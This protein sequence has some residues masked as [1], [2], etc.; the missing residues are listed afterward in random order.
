MKIFAPIQLQFI[1]FLLASLALTKQVHAQVY[2]KG[3]LLKGRILTVER[4]DSANI[5]AGK[6]DSISIPLS[7]ATV[8]LLSV[9]DSAFAAGGISDKE[10]KFQLFYTRKRQGVNH[11]LVKVSYLGM[12]SYQRELRTSMKEQEADLGDITLRPKAMTLQEAQIVGELKKMYMK[13]DTLIYNTD[14]Y[15]MP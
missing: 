1:L 10:G 3:L 6:G 9:P 11:L 4:T 2:T 12:E 14:A 8:Q 13:G 15:E 5:S 7:N